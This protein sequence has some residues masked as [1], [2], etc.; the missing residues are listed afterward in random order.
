[1]T[2][3]LQAE[4]KTIVDQL[5]THYKPEKII[6][7]GS[8]ARGE[9]TDESDLYILVVKKTDDNYHDRVRE[10]SHFVS[11]QRPLDI[12]VLTPDELTKAVDEKRL[13][14]RQIFKYG[15]TLYEASAQ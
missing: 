3:Q 8:G 10:V 1:M 15:T 13:F 12:V 2:K 4:I 5:V 14:I 9:A 6:L 7:F 11:S